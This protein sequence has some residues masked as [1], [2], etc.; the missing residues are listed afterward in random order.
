MNIPLRYTVGLANKCSIYKHLRECEASFIPPLSS[1]VDIRKY[2]SK[3]AEL[4]TNFECWHKKHLAGLVA[5]YFNDYERQIAFITTVSVHP[6]YRGQGIGR[7]L[8]GMCLRQAKDLGFCEVRLEV[9]PLN[10]KAVKL[11]KMFDFTIEFLDSNTLKMKV[12]LQ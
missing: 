3:I 9:S 4:A 2:A 1:R 7:H 12:Q 10:I 5:A 8:I 6:S 11:Y